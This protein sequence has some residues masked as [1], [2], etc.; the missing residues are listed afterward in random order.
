M[1][2]RNLGAIIT[3]KLL[4]GGIV[5]TIIKGK[6]QQSTFN[7]ALARTK[8]LKIKYKALI[9]LSA[10][11]CSDRIFQFSKKNIR[12]TILSDLFSGRRNYRY[13]INS[14]V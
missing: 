5:V 7:G 12:F 2:R 6:H 4:I 10:E 13:K 8:K 3:D 14:S 9:N 1:T 11:F